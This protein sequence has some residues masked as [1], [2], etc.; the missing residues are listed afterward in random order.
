MTKCQADGKLQTA[1]R[2]HN[3]TRSSWALIGLAI[4]IAQGLGLHRDADVQGFGIFEAEMRRRLWWQLIVLDVR[5]TED[6]GSEP[7][8]AEG[9]FNTRMPHNLNDEDFAK[10]SQ[11][12][13][14]DRIGLTEMSF[15][16]MCMI[17][18]DAG[19]KLN[20]IP[21]SSEHHAL[22]IEQKEQ[23]VR[24]CTERI[25]S[26]YLSG[27]D[28]SAPGTLLVSM[29]GRLFILKLWLI[30]QFPL[31]SRKSIAPEF[32]KSESLR[33]VVAYLTLSDTIE[34]SKVAAGLRWFFDTYVP[35]HA[36]A[37]AL[38]ELCT[39]TQGPLVDQ[40][41]TIIDK[42]YSKWSDRVADT[43][44]GMLWRPVK[45][46]FKRARAARYGAQVVSG[47]RPVVET[48]LSN[49]LW[50]DMDIVSGLPNLSLE[51][52]MRSSSSS[53]MPSGLASSTRPLGLPKTKSDLPVDLNF[54]TPLDIP[55][56]AEELNGPINWDDWNAF[57][58]D[59]NTNGT[60]VVSEMPSGMP[61][62]W[63]I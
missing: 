28:P 7:V 25:E 54:S 36:L 60:D 41:W 26:H 5:A 57:I 9:A 35:W 13:L 14:T 24:Q 56:T 62:E 50:Q 34:D 6:R 48:R 55:M 32:P 30:V 43:K 49:P 51:G 10:D 45:R 52:P 17:I 58:S 3:K 23:V 4:R 16:I 46:L 47:M 1:I 8:I 12:E 59:V 40:A 39:Q 44:E 31:Q 2:S 37:V 27:C 18:S 15:C 20:F 38:A 21:L 42:C 33:T 19:R 11:H 22:T 53:A 61:Y 63:P 29:L